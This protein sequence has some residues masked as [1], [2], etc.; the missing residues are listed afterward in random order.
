MSDIS[1]PATA[2]TVPTNSLVSV[3]GGV[4]IHID[5]DNNITI[6]GQNSIKFYSEGDL[7]IGAR[8]VSIHA[9]ESMVMAVDGDVYIG[10]SSHIIQQA[11]RIDLNPKKDSSGYFGNIKSRVL[12]MFNYLK[13]KRLSKRIYCEEIRD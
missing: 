13:I 12:E 1:E 8:N 9:T 4:K 3:E 6:Y 5:K 2:V 11:P 10:S 7:D